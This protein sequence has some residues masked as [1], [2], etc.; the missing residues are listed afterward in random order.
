MDLS[1]QSD[2]KSHYK[3]SPIPQEL[4]DER[5]DATGRQRRLDK[6]TYVENY[7]VPLKRKRR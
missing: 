5:R 6:Q 3:M 2:E 4:V 7:E 1:L